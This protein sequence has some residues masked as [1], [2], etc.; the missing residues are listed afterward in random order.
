ML[1]WFLVPVLLQ[2]GGWVIFTN[3]LLNIGATTCFMDMLFAHTHSFQTVMKKKP[4]LVEGIDRRLLSSGA[5]TEETTP[6][7]LIVGSHL[8]VITFDLISSPRHAV[9]LGLSWLEL[10]NPV[11]DWYWHSI[12]LT[13]QVRDEANNNKSEAGHESNNKNVA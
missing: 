11:V 6:L 9:I 12:D 8:N 7:E 5:I 1:K 10:R 13:T 2:V 4:I 3:A